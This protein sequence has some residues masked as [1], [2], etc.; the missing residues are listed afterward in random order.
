[1]AGSFKMDLPEARGELRLAHPRLHDLAYAYLK[2]LLLDGGL[3]P[4]DQI[5]SD[6]V[7]RALAIS[8]APVGD[9][10]RRLVM[11]GLLEVLPQIGCRVVTPVPAQVADFYELFAA[12][13]AVIAGFAAER[14]SEAE[15]RSFAQMLAD[16]SPRRG[17]PADPAERGPVLRQRNRR[18]YERLHELAASPL[19]V[20]IGASFWDRSDVF[21]RVAFGRFDTPP[22]VAA[23]QKALFAAVI[24]GDP[25]TARA[26]TTRYLSRLGRDVADALQAQQAAASSSPPA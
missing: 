14:R 7:G 12:T 26:E 11:D 21:I 23:A 5:S 10:I 6:G 24:A 15:A 1:M 20:G 3:D 13:E 17:L 18:R 19:N 4:G 8:R 2:G 22:Y 16:L 25:A 9:A